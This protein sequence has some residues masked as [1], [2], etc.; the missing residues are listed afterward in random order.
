MSKHLRRHLVQLA[1]RVS[2]LTI[3][4]S[5]SIEPLQAQQP[6]TSTWSLQDLARRWM[7]AFPERLCREE[8][9]PVIE[10]M[11]RRC[12]LQRGAGGTDT[13]ELLFEQGDALTGVYW[14]NRRFDDD[15]S[16][17]RF[18]DSLAIELAG[19]QFARWRC[20]PDS[21]NGF[22]IR[23]HAWTGPGASVIL[24]LSR[25]T[26][27]S[28]RLRVSF[29]DDSTGAAREDFCPLGERLSAPPAPRRGVVT[30]PYER[31]SGHPHPHVRLPMSA[32]ERARA[33]VG[34]RRHARELERR[35]APLEQ[36]NQH[37]SMRVSY[38]ASRAASRASLAGDIARFTSANSA[39]PGS[40]ANLDD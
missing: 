22:T 40:P 2:L 25:R 34:G 7:P 33:A 8:R 21:G 6:T 14:W 28:W 5:A 23:T 16:A 20:P 27:E 10:T 18:V 32:D 35:D 36:A 11:V 3:C 13:L 12:Y 31:S 38:I 24:G 1:V 29:H 19:A 26:K 9:E 15:A 17:T 4:A 39:G 30:A 37:E